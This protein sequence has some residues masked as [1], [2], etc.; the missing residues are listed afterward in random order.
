MTERA[1]RGYAHKRA[2]ALACFAHKLFGIISVK[3]KIKNVI[4]P[5]DIPIAR[6]SSIF[7]ERAISIAILVAREAVNV[8]RRLLPMSIVIRSVSVLFLSVWRIL[9]QIRFFFTKAS[10][11]CTG[12]DIIAISELE[13]KAEKNNRE[14]NNSIVKISI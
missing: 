7:E 3:V 6:P 12:S 2:I 5:V 11:A 9:D 13:K 8:L 10:T 1:L 4:I 14:I